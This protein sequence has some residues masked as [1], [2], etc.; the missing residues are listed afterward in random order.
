MVNDKGNIEVLI[1]EFS[2]PALIVNE[3]YPVRYNGELLSESSLKKFVPFMAVSILNKSTEEVKVFVNLANDNAFRVPANSSR[4]L[5][6]FPC[7]DI[8]VENIGSSPTNASEVFITVINDVEQV[9][10][11][12]SYN[13][14]R[15]Y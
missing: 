13:K 8:T 15:V 3:Q 7:W 14:G 9:G 4:I 6:G 10:R 11:F 1:K 2:V 12:N 5:S